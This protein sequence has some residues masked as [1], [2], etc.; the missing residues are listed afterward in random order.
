MKPK[1]PILPGKKKGAAQGVGAPAAPPRYTPD[2]I[3]AAMAALQSRIGLIAECMSDVPESV[4][5]MRALQVAVWAMGQAAS[6]MEKGGG[7]G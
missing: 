4:E 6:R 2:A 5:Y 7:Q 3:R 1:K